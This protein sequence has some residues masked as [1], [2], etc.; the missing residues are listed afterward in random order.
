MED[1]LACLFTDTACTTTMLAQI[2]QVSC[3][4]LSS[5]GIW[6]VSAMVSS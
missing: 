3:K 4:L 1:Q 6:L 2:C 5:L